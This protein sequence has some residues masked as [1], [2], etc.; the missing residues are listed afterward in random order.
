MLGSDT[1]VLRKR[2]VEICAR[3]GSR[4]PAGSCRFSRRRR[5]RFRD[6]GIAC[7]VGVSLQQ[8]PTICEARVRYCVGRLSGMLVVWIR[9]RCLVWGVRWLAPT[10]ELGFRCVAMVDSEA[11]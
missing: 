6:R 3:A 4:D 10:A 1:A 2:F 11:S 8:Q 9:G 7:G 5:G